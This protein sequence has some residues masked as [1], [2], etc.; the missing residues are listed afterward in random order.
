MQRN[1]NGT[2]PISQP[3]RST[4]F[5]TVPLAE[6]PRPSPSGDREA[7]RPVVLV[8]DDERA[9]ADTLTKILSRSGFAAMAAYDAETALETALLVPPQM[10]ISDVVLPGLSG[11]DLAIAL[12]EKIPDCKV[13][14]FSGMA[15]TAGLLA[16]AN[17]AGHSFQLLSKPIHP[18]D[19]LAHVSTSLKAPAAN[20]SSGNGK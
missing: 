2:L 6:V 20:S 9:I 3:N 19:L 18:S 5:P 7:Y 4:S 11:I 12:R 17:R 10:L 8:V 15:A 1:P 14:L 13:L 16:E